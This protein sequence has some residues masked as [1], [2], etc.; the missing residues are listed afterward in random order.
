ME[1]GGLTRSAIGVG[2]PLMTVLSIILAVVAVQVVGLAMF[3]ALARSNE[4]FDADGSVRSATT[5]TQVRAD[6]GARRIA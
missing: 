5:A 3:R 4:R 1:F 6:V 2:C